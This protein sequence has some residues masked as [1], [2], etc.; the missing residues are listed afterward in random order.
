[1]TEDIKDY[2]VDLLKSFGLFVLHLVECNYFL[3][4]HNLLRFLRSFHRGV[5]QDEIL[6]FDLPS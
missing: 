1:M 3:S 2:V 5:L 6:C 4:L